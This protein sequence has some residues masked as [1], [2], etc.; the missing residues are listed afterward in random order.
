[1]YISG[2]ALLQGIW[3][4]VFLAE[5]NKLQLW[6]VDVGKMYLEATIKKGLYIVGGPEFGSLEVHSL[7]I[8]QALY[9]LRS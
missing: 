2:V 9:G 4:I 6:G 1:V 3:L 8:D 5:L 7:V